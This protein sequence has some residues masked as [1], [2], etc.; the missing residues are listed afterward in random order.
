MLKIQ[1]RIAYSDNNITIIIKEV[2][3]FLVCLVG[4]YESRIFLT[5]E[6]FDKIIAGKVLAKSVVKVQYFT[7][8][9]ENCDSTRYLAAE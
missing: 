7:D 6:N 1:L 2:Q 4:I 5:R 3:V 9:T 8:N